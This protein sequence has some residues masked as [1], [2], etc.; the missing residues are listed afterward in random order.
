MLIVTIFVIA[1]SYAKYIAEASGTIERQAG[2]WVIKVNDTDISSSSS[3]TEFKIDKLTYKKNDYVE[4]GKI[5]PSSVGYFDV[6]I[7]PSG[8]STAV[9]FDV[10]IDTTELGIS[11]AINFTDAKIV[12]D[13]VESDKTLTRTAEKTYSGIISLDDVQKGVLTTARFYIK[14][15]DE[16]TTLG[17]KSDSQ[18]GSTKDV[19]LGLPIVVVVSQYLGE[20]LEEY[21]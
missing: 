13:G 14:W 5:A 2:A 10:T 4:E 6:T 12:V 18:I 3:E 9:R 8:T 15:N 16:E 1:N 11:D 7:D 21:K 19:S 17:D 20:T